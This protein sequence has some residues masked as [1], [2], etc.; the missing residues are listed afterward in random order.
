MPTSF[1]LIIVFFDGSFEYGDGR[2]F[3]LQ[4]WMQNLQRETIKL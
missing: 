4:R 2:I 3:K 1:I